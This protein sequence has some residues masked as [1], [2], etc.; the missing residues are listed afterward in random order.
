MRISPRSV[1]YYT[2]GAYFRSGTFSYDAFRMAGRHHRLV[3]LLRVLRSVQ[4][5]Q[6]HQ[7]PVQKRELPLVLRQV[8]ELLRDLPDERHRHEWSCTN[9]RYIRVHQCRM[10]R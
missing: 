9:V 3:L 8:R 1:L 7:L 4:V 10:L 2:S 6:E 5:L